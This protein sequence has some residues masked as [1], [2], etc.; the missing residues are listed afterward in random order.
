MELR[1]YNLSLTSML[2]VMKP[3]QAMSL[4]NKETGDGVSFNPK[5]FAALDSI[6]H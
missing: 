4:E 5:T 3:A 2:S 1:N 6:L